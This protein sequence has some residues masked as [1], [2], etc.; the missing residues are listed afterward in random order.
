[1]KDPDPKRQVLS[2]AME[3]ALA[4]CSHNRTE[5]LLTPAGA[6]LARRCLKCGKLIKHYIERVPKK[7]P[8]PKQSLK[9]PGFE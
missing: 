4:P 9:L 1:M 2:A 6:R 8:K 5:V 7:R 3:E